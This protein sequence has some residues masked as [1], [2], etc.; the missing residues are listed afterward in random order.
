MVCILAIE[1]SANKIGVGIIRDGEILSNP[2]RTFHGAIGEGFRPSETADHHRRVCA[3]VIEEALN[4][5]G[6]KVCLVLYKL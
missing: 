6:I 5:A 3:E 4:L 1:S 2:R